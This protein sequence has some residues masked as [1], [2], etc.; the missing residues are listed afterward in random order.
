M[1]ERIGP[2]DCTDCHTEIVS[3]IALRR[4]FR[5]GLQGAVG[6]RAFNTVGEAKINRAVALGDVG[7]PICHGDNLC[8]VSI[9]KSIVFIVCIN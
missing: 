1:D 6:N 5:A 4:Q 2:A 3:K 8:I 7:K 9:G